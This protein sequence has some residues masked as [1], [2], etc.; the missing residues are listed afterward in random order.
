[1]KSGT[2][3]RQ[4][5][6]FRYYLGLIKN[7]TRVP[8]LLQYGL[9]RTSLPIKFLVLTSF[10]FFLLTDLHADTQNDPNVFRMAI[11]T[12]GYTNPPAG[13]NGVVAYVMAKHGIKTEFKVVPSKRMPWS[14]KGGDIDSMQASSLARSSR[15]ADDKDDFIQSE[16]PV[17][18]Y[19]VLLYYKPSDRWKPEWPPSAAML[20]NSRGVTM[21]YNYLK[22]RGYNITQIPGYVS[23]ASMVNYGRTDYWL[24]AIPVNLLGP[25]IRGEDKG[26]R[27]EKYMDNPLF[28][29]FN[30]DERGRRFKTIWDQEVEQLYRGSTEYRQ[31]FLNNLESAYFTAAVEDFIL[32]LRQTYPDFSNIE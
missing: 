27:T 11:Y 10:Y 6:Y 8:T 3:T 12:P 25:L 17:F 31:V 5:H 26:F 1:M 20:E 28:L 4:K 15:S 24:D 18:S 14:L 9:L 29:L 21:N 2:F 23:G 22:L 32:Y 13:I 7:T 19:N 30:D 16:M